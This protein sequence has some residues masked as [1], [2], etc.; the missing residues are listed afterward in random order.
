M[1]YMYTNVGIEFKIITQE[2]N[3]KHYLK[4]PLKML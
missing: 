1:H 4:C 2:W 3:L